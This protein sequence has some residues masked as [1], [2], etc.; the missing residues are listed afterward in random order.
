MFG[1]D[2]EILIPIFAMAIPV[3]AIVG[4]I[5]AGIVRMILKARV[6]ELAQ[7]ERIA[8]IERGID[9]SKLSPLPLG[10]EV[11][12]GPVFQSPRQATL[13][14]ARGLLVGGIVTLSV[15]I[16]LGLMLLFLNDGSEHVWAVGLI[17]ALV[18]LALLVSSALMRRAAD[19]DSGTAPA[20]APRA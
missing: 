3:V 7:R 14:R 9:P 10:V 13:H 8:A 11:D 15:G 2:A 18:G 17:P 6:L 16:G 1:F 20:P 5:T 12:E 4:G 19:E